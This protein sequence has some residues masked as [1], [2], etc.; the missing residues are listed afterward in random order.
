VTREK[1]FKKEE[2]AMVETVV[3]AVAGA[4]AVAEETGTQVVVAAVAGIV[5]VA[6]ET[7]AEAVV[8][9]VAGVV[10]VAEETGTEAVVAAVVGVVAVAEETGTKV[11]VVVVVV[12]VEA[13]ID[14][15]I[16]VAVVDVWGAERKLLINNISKFKQNRTYTTKLTSSSKCDLLNIFFFKRQSS[17]N[18]SFATLTLSPRAHTY[19]G[20]TQTK[21]FYNLSV[22]RYILRGTQTKYTYNLSVT[23]YTFAWY[24]FYVCFCP[25]FTPD[26]GH[27]TQKHACVTLEMY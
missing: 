15:A 26:N 3:A 7:G 14:V 24:R 18:S 5:A 25:M 9:A 11:V 21:Y 2:I 22:I 17:S 8:A 20:R 6:E 10:A 12:A 19:H 27:R 23:L 16:A 1:I 13:V 4:V